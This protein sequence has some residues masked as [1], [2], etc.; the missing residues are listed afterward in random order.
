MKR[1]N[2]ADLAQWLM[3]VAVCVLLGLT[4][5]FLSTK[6]QDE[7]RPG[8]AAVCVVLAVFLFLTT[9]RKLPESQRS[10]GGLR[11]ALFP[12]FCFCSCS[13]MHPVFQGARSAAAPTQCLSNV[14]QLSV[15]MQIYLV[16]SEDRMPPASQWRTAV[17]LYAKDGLVN[18]WRCPYADTKWTHGLNRSLG[19]F[20]TTMIE[21]ETLTVMLFETESEVPNVTGGPS[22]V[23]RRHKGG[24]HFGFLDSRA[25]WFDAAAESAL[26]WSPARQR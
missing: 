19:S 14:K 3:I 9:V 1:I 21:D 20:D 25:K 4:G 12:I 13:I 11:L 10:S 17:A 26:V 5:A 7:Y 18:P 2:P 15:A 22:D 6:S 23:V 24:S 16:D 8:W